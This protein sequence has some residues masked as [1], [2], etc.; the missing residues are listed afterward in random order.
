MPI[1]A[2]ADLPRFASL[3]AWQ[4][5]TY[6]VIG[7]R[8]TNDGGKIYVC[9][10][11]GTSAGAGG[12]TGNGANIVDGTTRW[13]FVAENAPAWV[14]L[15]AYA[16]GDRVT[17]D[18]GRIYQCIVAGTSGAAPGPTGTTGTLPPNPAITDGTVSWIFTA[19]S[20]AQITE[21]SAGQKDV[22]WIPGQ[23]PPAQYFNWLFW[24]IYRWLIWLNQYTGN[25]IN[26]ARTDQTNTFTEPQII[27]ADPEAAAS[28][29]SLIDLQTAATNYAKVIQLSEQAAGAIKPRWYVTPGG[30]KVFTMNAQ[31]DPVGIVWVSDNNAAGAQRWVWGANT[32]QIDTHAAAVS[33]VDGAWSSQRLLFDPITGDLTI[34]GTLAADSGVSSSAGDF[35][36][37]AGSMHAEGDPDLDEGRIYGKE[38]IGEGAAPAAANAGGAGGAGFAIN[39]ISGNSMRGLVSFITGAAPAGGATIL[40]TL[41]KDYPA[42]PV[43]HICPAVAGGPA[44]EELNAAACNWAVGIVAIGVGGNTTFQISI[45]G[46]TIAAGTNY[47]FA[48]HVIG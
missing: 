41:D 5:A 21:P 8:V 6:Y 15:T 35:T 37:T 45:T 3:D 29:L 19:D 31:W 16:L 30:G 46:A 47:G 17:N 26:A 11:D 22:G 36:A 28:A 20:E 13:D 27:D 33:W 48:Y 38:I 39:A 40:V 14:T 4:A 1:A 42:V 23:R 12:P 9:D 43:V 32:V 34:V 18:G 44:G 25:V 7:E 2:P 24:L 10:T